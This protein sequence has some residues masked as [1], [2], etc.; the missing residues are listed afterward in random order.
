MS[1]LLLGWTALGCVGIGI[2]Q[3]FSSKPYTLLS[4]GDQ[5]GRDQLANRWL[6]AESP[7]KKLIEGKHSNEVLTILGQPQKVDVV[8]RNTSEDWYYVYYKNY[9]TRPV[10]DKGLFIV[11]LYDNHVLDS[12]KVE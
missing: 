4:G 2:P 1:L 11:R 3:P 12:Q 7:A 9:K 8:E 10:T 6:V 5:L